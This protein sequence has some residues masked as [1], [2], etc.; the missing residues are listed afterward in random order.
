MQKVLK[1]PFILLLLLSSTFPSNANQLIFVAEDLPPFHFLDANNKPTGALVEVIEAMLLKT[2]Y[3]GFINLMPFAHSYDAALN[4][5]NTLI[6]S[7]MKTTKR[8]KYFQ[9]IGHIYKSKAFLIGLRSRTDINIHSLEEAKSFVVGTIRGYHS[10]EYLKNAGFSTPQNLHLSVNY[11]HM[12][13]MLFGRHI[14]FILT[15]FVAIDREMKSIGF[16]KEE[17]KPIVELY[18][19][20]GDLFIATGLTTSDKVVSELSDAL[21]K[22]KD[23]GTY[24]KIIDKWGL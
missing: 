20:P 8:S 17:I 7:L 11:K 15:N 19:F 6:F 1:Y 12:W 2:R 22:I 21:H 4:Q 18:D 14:D 23:D 16:D 10:E 13:G 3:T 9:W 24:Q 5:K